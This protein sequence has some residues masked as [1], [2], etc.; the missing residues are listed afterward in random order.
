MLIPKGSIVFVGIWALHH[1]ESDYAN[2]DQ[3]DP[4]R[5]LHHPKLAND[6]AVSPDYNN[7][8]KYCP[9]RSHGL[10]LT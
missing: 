2:H 1:S 3:F 6:Y 7:R 4:D 5:Y 9:S 10:G 8:D